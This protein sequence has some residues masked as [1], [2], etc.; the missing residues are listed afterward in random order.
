MADQADRAAP[1][2]GDQ[3]VIGSVAVVV[4]PRGITARVGI[5]DHGGCVV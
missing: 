4:H 2:Q 3:Q 1:R 5:R